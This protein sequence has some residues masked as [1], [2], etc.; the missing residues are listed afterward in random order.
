M[1]P[2]DRPIIT[3]GYK[4]NTWKVISFVATEDTGR[5]K[6]SIHYLSDYPDPFENVDIISV[7]RP[8]SVSKLFGYFNQVGSHKKFIQYYL[9]L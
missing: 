7:T 1:M 8:I 3:I 5:K 9:E 6:A 2:R 4:Y